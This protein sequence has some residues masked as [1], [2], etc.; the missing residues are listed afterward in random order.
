MKQVDLLNNWL[1][2]TEF[3]LIEGQPRIFAISSNKE[4][5]SEIQEYVENYDYDFVYNKF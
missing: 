5:L 3:E 4:L 1:N 2:M